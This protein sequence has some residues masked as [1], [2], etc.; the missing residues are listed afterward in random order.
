MNNIRTFENFSEYGNLP[1]KKYGQEFPMSE[2][3]IGTEIIYAG[4]PF[5][6]DKNDGFVLIAKSVKNGSVAKINQ[7]MFN[8]R[9]LI[10]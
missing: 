3:N 5:I 10:K 1:T 6:V 9:V 4:T 8:Q 7:N 2:V